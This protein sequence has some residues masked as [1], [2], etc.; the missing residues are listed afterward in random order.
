M[1]VKTDCE[2]DGSSAALVSN[3]RGRVVLC[4]ALRR[5]GAGK[6][7]HLHLTLGHIWAAEVITANIQINNPERVRAHVAMSPCGS[8]ENVPRPN[9]PSIVFAS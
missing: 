5:V 2:T 4:A 9:D 7:W 8:V 6:L 1:I 3:H